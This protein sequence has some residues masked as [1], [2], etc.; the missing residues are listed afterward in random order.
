M[1]GAVIR[2]DVDVA[3]EF[4]AAIS[5]L[6]ADKKLVALASAGPQRTAYLPDVPTVIES[7]F[8]G[9]EVQSWNG[10]SVPAATPASVI[11]TL[12]SAM[13]DVMPAPE[14]Q[15]RAKQ[16]GMAMR[17]ST[18]EDMTARLKADIAKWGAVIEQA[19][20]AKRD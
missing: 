17:W 14:V 4:Y 20:I 10:L 8:K 19:G 9:F 11:S 16:L 7:G 13:K 18:P 5:G 12:N 1:A 6:L 15:D 3:F 2:G